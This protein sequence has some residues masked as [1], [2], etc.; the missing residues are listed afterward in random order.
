MSGPAGDA[1]AFSSD[2]PA[3]AGTRGA[4][5]LRGVGHR[6]TSDGWALDDV[7]LELQP[8]VTALVGV[9]GAGKSTLLSILAGSL[10]PT[11]GLV[12]ITGVDLNGSRRSQALPHVALMPQSLTLP[13]NLSALEAVSVIGWMRGL[14]ARDARQRAASA[15]EAVDLQDRMRSRVKELSGGMKRRLALAQA[16]VAEPRVLLLDE[17]S[18]GLDP[19]QRRRMVDIVKNLT[20]TVLFSSHVM[21]DVVDAATR[22][23]VLHEGRVLFDGDVQQLSALAPS[24]AAPSRRPEAAFLALVTGSEAT[25]R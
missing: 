24:D 6:Y 4:A 19:Q 12:M 13:D 25:G 5:E 15:L 23:V 16:I 18:T 14:R 10:R 2:S 3:S 17:P 7:D 8:G 11:T 22:V 9:N 21:E 1:A 20:G